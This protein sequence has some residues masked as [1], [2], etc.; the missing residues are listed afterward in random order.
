MTERE[1]RILLI[2]LSKQLKKHPDMKWYSTKEETAYNEGILMAKS[3]IRS[4][5]ES[6]INSGCR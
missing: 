5:Y 2:M 1:C 4:F 6:K 3:I